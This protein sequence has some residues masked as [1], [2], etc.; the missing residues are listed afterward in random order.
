MDG[1]AVFFGAMLVV[2]FVMFVAV[3]SLWRERNR[4]L[5]AQNADRQRVEKAS[6]T[7]ASLRAELQSVR[8]N[9]SR[10]EDEKSEALA[11]RQSAEAGKTDAEK[12]LALKNQ[13]LGLMRSQMEDWEKTKKETIEAAK[14]GAIT[15][16]RELS[17]KL[18]EDHKLESKASNDEKEKIFKESVDEV[19]NKYE[20]ISQTIASF[21]SKVQEHGER[22]DTV[23]RALTSPGGAADVAE[24]GLGNAL[25]NIGLEQGRDF[26]LQKTIQGQRLRPDAVVFMPGD[27]VLIIDSKSSKWIVEMAQAEGQGAEMEQ[28]ALNKFVDRMNAHLKDLSS[29]NYA[30]AVEETYRN[31][32]RAGRITRTLTLMYLPSESALEK[33]GSADPKFIEKCRKASVIPSGHSGLYCLI[34]FARSEIKLSRQTENQAKIVEQTGVLL[35]RVAIVLENAGKIGRGL[36]SATKAYGD[37]ARSFNSR[38]L[39]KVSELRALGVETSRNDGFPDRMQSLQ[40]VADE[41]SDVIEGEAEEIL[42]IGHDSSNSEPG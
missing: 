31:S 40:V 1:S 27:S 6:S 15:S 5:T 29:K 22:V 13:E 10:L 30:S 7:E 25:K 17:S 8:E 4:L 16:A 14:A 20:K 35:D 26:V 28:S 41:G 38:L 11:K 36:K 2:L 3:I 24:V 21:H 12:E 23:W 32:G 33:L 9:L 34:G 42:E 19:R 18:L 39:P 37:M